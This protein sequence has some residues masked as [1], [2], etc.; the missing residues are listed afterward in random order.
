MLADQLVFGLE[1]DGEKVF[2]NIGCRRQGDVAVALAA[3]GGLE[4]GDLRKHGW[5]TLCTALR[6]SALTGLASR[7]RLNAIP[8]PTA[9]P[10]TPM[11]PAESPCDALSPGNA[12]FDQL[13]RN[14]SAQVSVGAQHDARDHSVIFRAVQSNGRMAADA[15][16]Q[17]D[18]V[19]LAGLKANVSNDFHG[20]LGVALVADEV[21]FFA[22]AVRREYHAA[23]L[24][25]PVLGFSFVDKW[26]SAHHA[27]RLFLGGSRER[28][29]PQRRQFR[30]W[31]LRRWLFFRFFFRGDIAGA[32]VFASMFTT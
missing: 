28:E 14:A 13:V 2:G 27:A 8:T 16:E 23:E 24:A 11:N 3:A 26:V 9:A 31:L 1:G 19:R 12:R 5:V 6:S 4:L 7:I 25:M 18:H 22:G 20:I 30:P 32:G 21:A 17:P 15:F 10:Q 29:R